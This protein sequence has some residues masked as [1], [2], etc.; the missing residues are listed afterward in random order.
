MHNLRAG[1]RIIKM[2]ISSIGQS[3]EAWATKETDIPNALDQW[4]QAQQLD[5]LL[6]GTAFFDNEKG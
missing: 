1:S 4:F 2:G 3:L 5:L 6:A